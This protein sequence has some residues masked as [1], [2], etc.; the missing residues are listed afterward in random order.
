MAL[1][2]PICTVGAICIA[3]GIS[4]VLVDPIKPS[5]WAKDYSDWD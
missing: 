2:I 5:K 3:W 1:L 4:S